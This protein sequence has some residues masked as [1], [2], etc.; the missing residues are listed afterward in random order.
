MFDNSD[1]YEIVQ[2]HVPMNQVPAFALF[3]LDKKKQCENYMS[4]YVGFIFIFR[5]SSE[6]NLITSFNG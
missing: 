1:D 2:R 5:L 3:D 6:K 4:H